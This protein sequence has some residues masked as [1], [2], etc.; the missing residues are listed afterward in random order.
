MLAFALVM[1]GASWSQC[2]AAHLASL[3][4]TTASPSTAAQSVTGE[5]AHHHHQGAL[6]Q[7][8]NAKAGPSGSGV[9][10]PDDHACQKCCA[11]CGVTTVLGNSPAMEVTLAEHSILFAPRR[12]PAAGRVLWLDPEIPKHLS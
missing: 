2:I 6:P 3:G 11:M 9:N 10:F 8:A 5:H 12:D 7:A 1:S 4:P